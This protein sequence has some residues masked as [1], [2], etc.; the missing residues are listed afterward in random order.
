[1]D[2]G[3]SS[4]ILR[5]S[6]I[7]HDVDTL[8]AGTPQHPFFTD[9]MGQHQR[10]SNGDMLLTE[11]VPG[12]VLEVDQD[13]RTVWEYYNLVRPG[14]RGTVSDAYRLPRQFDERFFTQKA[15]ECGSGN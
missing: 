12:R 10:L 11:S 14:V 8:Y 13:G 3:Q 6:A 7:S 15:A 5:F 9:V 4:R 2:S 1:V